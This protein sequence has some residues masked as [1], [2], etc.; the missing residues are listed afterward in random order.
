MTTTTFQKE[1]KKIV[2]KH[3][4][5][6]EELKQ[7][8]ARVEQKEEDLPYGDWELKPAAIKRIERTSRELKAGK[9]IRIRTEEE[10]R[11]FFTSL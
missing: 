7:V 3:E 6:G 11:R 5:L 1:L 8:L 2:R 4:K 9:G 10:L